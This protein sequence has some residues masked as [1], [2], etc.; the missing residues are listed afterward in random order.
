MDNVNFALSNQQLYFCFTSHQSSLWC[1][2]Y[3]A[4]CQNA[5]GFSQMNKWIILR[6]GNIIHLDRKSVEILYFLS[7]SQHTILIFNRKKIIS[8]ILLNINWMKIE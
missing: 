2:S 8:G 6:I 1:C 4:S 5:S 3:G 7:M